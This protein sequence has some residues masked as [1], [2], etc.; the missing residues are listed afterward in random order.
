M[1]YLNISHISKG[2]APAAGPPYCHPSSQ[3][4]VPWAYLLG[5]LAPLLGQIGSLY[6]PIEP[7][8]HGIGSHGPH[9]WLPLAPFWVPFESL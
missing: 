1:L 2:Y 8:D 4:Y 6:L 5:P 7:F 9:Y 3:Y